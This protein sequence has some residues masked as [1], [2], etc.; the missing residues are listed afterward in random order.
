MGNTS[1]RYR[2]WHR[3]Y[4]TYLRYGTYGIH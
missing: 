1:G 4:G 3:T 2:D